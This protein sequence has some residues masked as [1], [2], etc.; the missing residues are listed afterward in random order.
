MREDQARAARAL[1]PASFDPITN[2]HLDIVSRSLQVFDTLVL[3]VASNVS[4]NETFSLED[5]LEMLRSAVGDEP[6]LEVTSFDGLTVDFAR[7]IGA[8]VIIRGFRAMS[9][10]EYE[11]EMALMNRHLAPDLETIFRARRICSSAPPASRSSCASA[12]TSPS[13]SRPWWPRSCGRS[14]ARADPTTA[15]MR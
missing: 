9:D 15:P 2:G 14:S 1:F 6:R 5:R 3:A 13:S 10:F 11:F 4:K 12:E 7:K 8:K